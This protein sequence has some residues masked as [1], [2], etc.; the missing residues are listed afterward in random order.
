MAIKRASVKESKKSVKKETIKKGPMSPVYYAVFRVALPDDAVEII[1]GNIREAVVDAVREAL[2][3]RG[4][5]WDDID[6]Q[7]RFELTTDWIEVG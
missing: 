3:G 6:L 4:K 1:E 2:K 5:V 7:Y